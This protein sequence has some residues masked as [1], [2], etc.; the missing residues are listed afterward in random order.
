MN[1][2]IL[3]SSVSGS[4]KSTY[5]NK[6]KMIA[7]ADG[8]ECEIHSTDNYHMRFNRDTGGW[9]YKFDRDKLGAYHR[10]NQEAAAISMACNVDVVVIDNTNLSFKE[11]K[12]Y[13]LLASIFD[14]EVEIVEPDTSWMH[15]PEECASRNVHGVPL[16]VIK[17]MFS[18]KTPI[19]ILKT[20]TEALLNVV[21]GFA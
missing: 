21:R 12:P 18:R 11:L 6:L 4:G 7:E 3:L 13:V 20:K 16:S 1:K 10:K 17:N 9:E 2:L 19:D 14:Y 8:L 15:I 5:A